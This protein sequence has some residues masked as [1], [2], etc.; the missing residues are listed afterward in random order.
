M[1]ETAKR[2]SAR[3]TALETPLGETAVE[4][5]EHVIREAA[6]LIEAAKAETLRDDASVGILAAK[7][8]DARNAIEGAA[9]RL[10]EEAK[11]GLPIKDIRVYGLASAADDGDD[12]ACGVISMGEPVHRRGEFLI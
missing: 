5:V 10:L 11:E 6:S 4:A 7:L 9:S 2:I 1:I 8:A 3:Q 12:Y